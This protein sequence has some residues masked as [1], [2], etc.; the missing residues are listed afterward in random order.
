MHR[1]GRTRR[2]RV[3]VVCSLVVAS[4]AALAQ[5]SAPSESPAAAF[6][7]RALTPPFTAEVDALRDAPRAILLQSAA[8]R[9]DGPLGVEAA[10]SALP[11]ELRGAAPIDG[12]WMLVQFEPELQE[13]ARQAA[14]SRHGAL[15]G[16]AVPH[17]A[18]LAFVPPGAAP[19]L[20]Q[21]RGVVWLGRLHPGLKLSPELATIAAAPARLRV[22]LGGALALE[23]VVAA[24]E[25]A[26]SRVIA[27]WADGLIVEVTDASRVVA[28]AAHADVIHVEP[29]EEPRLFNDQSRGIVQSGTIGTDGIHQR[30]VRGT[31]QIIAAMDS[32][33]DAKHCC[34]DG[35]GK[36]VDNRAWGGGKLGALCGGDHGTHVSGTAACDNG[37]DHDGLAPAAK[38]IMQDIQADGTF[39][40]SFGS[41]SPPGDLSTAWRDARDRG[42]FVHTNSWGG[43]GNSYGSSANAIDKFMWENPNFLVLFAAGNSGSGQRSLGSYSNAKNS[44]TVGGTKNGTAFEDM[45]SSSSR[46]PAG[47]G[48]ML[49]DFLAPAQGVSSAR[50]NANPS[51]GWTTYSGTSMAT[52]AAAGAAAL[53]RDFFV[54]GFYPSGSASAVNGFTPSASLL[55]ATMLL[56]TR[57]MQG[58]GTRGP[59]PNSDQGF[60]RV[61]LDDALWFAGETE[62]ARFVILDDRNVNT[63]FTALGQEA[64][65]EVPMTGARPVKVMLT[66]TDAPAA[67][68]AAKALINDLDLEVTT[69]DGKTYAGNQGFVNG[70]TVTPSTTFDRLNNKEGVFLESPA[71]GPVTI[72]VRAAAIGDVVLHPQDYSLVVVA[73]TDLECS[74]AQATGV[75]A[76]LDVERAGNDLR[77][78]FANRSAASYTIYRGTS[79]DFMRAQPNPHRTGVTDADAGTSGV[80]W[81]DA[82][83]AGN[84]TS[85]YY[86]AYSANSCGELVP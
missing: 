40:C 51:C 21:E 79:P 71:P 49:P 85:Y 24:I 78:D 45:Y 18:R 35:T 14:L 6:W 60:G 57:N 50:N 3:L 75:G 25:R 81:F 56:S 84:G 12:G 7:P 66:W 59:R 61:T 63:G 83:A 46:G 39:A 72:R 10:A 17:H 33:L 55:K 70:W 13:S 69:A 74:A 64:T 36:I 1:P 82:G 68:G 23:D 80:Q 54:R 5:A 15:A 42:A 47:D 76:T 38:L 44:I 77:L 29:Y 26:G 2:T 34:F 73:P 52:P 4:T 22:S 53:V 30:G 31:N 9:T 43:G 65:F 27:A 20:A 62:D 11:S 41:V 8:F 16:A 86:L 58:A 48:R 67:S 28:V 32:G 19:A 37:G